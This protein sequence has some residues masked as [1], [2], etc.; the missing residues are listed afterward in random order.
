VSS[1]PPVRHLRSYRH[2]D[3]NA[4]AVLHS[5]WQPHRAAEATATGASPGRKP[6]RCTEIRS[7][8]SVKMKPKSLASSNESIVGFTASPASP[9]RVALGF[10]PTLASDTSGRPGARPSCRSHTHTR[11]SGTARYLVGASDGRPTSISERIRRAPSRRPY[12]PGVSPTLAGELQSSARDVRGGAGSPIDETA[13]PLIHPGALPSVSTP[14]AALPR[15]RRMPSAARPHPESSHGDKTSD[16]EG[17]D[18]PIS[19]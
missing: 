10:A 8:S 2:V 15:P 14:T 11:C 13:R 3:G 4:L 5:R 1:R 12:S 16:R 19:D 7:P 6:L 18:P 17:D 9:R